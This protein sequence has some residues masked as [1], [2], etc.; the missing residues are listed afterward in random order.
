MP[1]TRG[2]VKQEFCGRFAANR[3]QCGGKSSLVKAKGPGQMGQPG[4]HHGKQ[5]PQKS[6]APV[7]AATR[8]SC[9]FRTRL[10]HTGVTDRQ[11]VS[12][13]IERKF[14]VSLASIGPARWSATVSL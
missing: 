10:L 6:S 11:L 8:A 7:H 9:R 13:K 12:Q 4:A 3:V 1:P 5:S 14:Q 2:I